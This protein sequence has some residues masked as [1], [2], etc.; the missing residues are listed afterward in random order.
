MFAIIETGGKQYKVAEG[1][2]IYVEKLDAAEGDK[3]TFDKVLALQNSAGFQT[4]APYVV[5]AKVAANVVKNGRGK[6]IYVM[7]YKAKK[8]EKRK[9]AIDSPTLRFRSTRSKAEPYNDQDPVFSPGRN[10]LRIRGDG[11]YRIRGIGGRCSLRRAFRYDHAHRE[12]G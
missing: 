9:W 2:I 1:D 8:N 10:I 11:A 6:K 4:G 3:V 7:T 5:G 12:Y